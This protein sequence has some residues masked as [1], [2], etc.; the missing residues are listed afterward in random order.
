MHEYTHVLH[1]GTIGGVCA[2]AI[3]A[4]LGLGLGVVYAP[5]QLQPRWGLEGLAVFEETA[6]TA[7]G[8]LR[9]AIWDM[10]LRAADARGK[11]SSASIR[12]RSRPTS[13]PSATRPTSTARR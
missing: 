5:N 13:S 9:N 12:S 4:V 10:Y 7:A 11:A 1:T 3:N 2:K 8:R 6:R